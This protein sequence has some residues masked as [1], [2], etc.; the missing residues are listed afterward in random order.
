[1]AASLPRAV[2]LRQ[3]RHLLSSSFAN[4]DPS[5]LPFLRAYALGFAFESVPSFIRIFLSLVVRR[6][7]APR[8]SI[9]AVLASLLRVVG[10]GLNPRGGLATA[11]GVAVGGGKWG[12]SRVEPF[13]RKL[14]LRALR[15]VRERREGRGSF[16][17]KGVEDDESIAK[18][19]ALEEQHERSI[20]QL[21]TFVASTFASLVSISLLQAS[22]QYS[23][24]K[25][26]SPTLDDLQFV[27]SPSPYPSLLVE[28]PRPS[29]KALS[30]T[31][32]SSKL[33]VAQSPTLDI[34][35]FVFVRA[36]DTIV[37]AIYEHTGVTSG[38]AGKLVASAASQADTL[39]FWISTWRIM[40]CWFYS[41]HLLPP[42]YNR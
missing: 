16:K 10:K 2:Q 27:P 19:R 12:E 13:V 34:T 32:P 24:P 1:M 37:R 9:L 22:P 23:R 5:T 31:S 18:D 30:S 20:K 25:P 6:K 11:L 14:Y 35:L 33:P 38:R 21:S 26:C 17:G 3:V 39:V 15:R 29:S 40:W 4:A 7:G 28:T 41:P 8:A 42:S 36:A